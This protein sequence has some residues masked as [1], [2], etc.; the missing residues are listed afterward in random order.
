MPPSFSVEIWRA[1]IEECDP[2]TLFVLKSVSTVFAAEV[3]SVL[4]ARLKQTLKPFLPTSLPIASFWDFLDATGCALIGTVALSVW[5]ERRSLTPRVLEVAVPFGAQVKV[6]SWL[7]GMGYTGSDGHVPMGSEDVVESVK[8]WTR[9][10]VRYC[11]LS[12]G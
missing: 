2:T 12:Y 11:Y 8:R 7:E 3:L 6:G 4:K 10:K 1:V 5:D 9:S